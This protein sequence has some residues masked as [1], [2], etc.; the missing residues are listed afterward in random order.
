MTHEL[1]ILF[2]EDLSTD[3]ELA[4]RQLR[5]N[6]LNYE[7]LRVDTRDDF[8]NALVTFQPDLIISDYSMPGFDGMQALQMAKELYPELPFV[9]LTGSMNEDTA[10]ECMKA[11]A[12][13]YVIKEHIN[14]LPFAVRE[15]L[16][17]AQDQK[18]K[19]FTEKQLKQSEAKFRGIFE[20]A[21]VGKA[22][23]TTTETISVND[24]F[25]DLLGY[26][27]EEIVNT[28]WDQITH[29][30]DIEMTRKIDNKLYSGETDAVRYEKRYIHKNGSIIW[31]DL[32]VQVHRDLSGKPEY[33]ISTIIDISD[34]KKAGE[35]LQASEKKFRSLFQ[36]NHA[37]MLLI[38]PVTGDI[39][40]VNPA[41]IKYYGFS[42]QEL[43]GKKISEINTLSP[44]EIQEEMQ[45]ALTEERNYFNF[46]HRLAN[47]DIRDVEVYSGP[48]QHLGR[49][50]LYS[51][52]HDVTDR[53]QAEI[54]LRKSEEKFKSF[55]QNNLSV[56]LLI[57]PDTGIITDANN[58]ACHFYGCDQ[59]TLLETNICQINTLP[60]DEVFAAITRAI[61]V[62]NNSFQ[63]KHRLANGDIRDVEVN[64][65]PIEHQNKKILYSIVHDVTEK[66]QAEQQ[67]RLQATA[68]NAAANAI[69]I[70]DREGNIQWVN[71]AYTQLTGYS[72]EEVIGQN[73]RILKSG[74]QD[75]AYY[76]RLWD[77]ILSGK[78]WD[79]E[80]INKRK[81]GSLYTEDETITPMFD[82]QGNIS[83]FIEI[84]EDITQ[85]K[86]AELALREGEQRYRRLFEDSPVSIWEENFSRVKQRLDQLKA[87]GVEDFYEY[88]ATNRT[89]LLEI[90][91]LIE[92]ID[93]N[94]ETI[95][96]FGARNKEELRDN[97]TNIYT[98]QSLNQLIEEL[99]N[100]A[101]GIMNFDIDF[102][103]KTLDGRVLEFTAKWAAQPGYENTLSKVLIS[104][105]DITDRKKAEDALRENEQRYRS[106]FDDSPVTIF[107]ED[108]SAVKTFIDELKQ[109]GVKDF[110]EFLNTNPDELKRIIRSIKITD[111][112][113]EAEKLYG[114]KTKQEFYGNFEL[115]TDP[116]NLH[117]MVDELVNIAEEKTKFQT[118]VYKHDSKGVLSYL[119]VNW[120][121]VPG[122][123]DDLSKVIVTVVDI[124]E[125]KELEKRQQQRLAEMEA[126]DKITSALRQATTR[127][128]ALPI[129]LQETLAMMQVNI[130]FILLH[131]STDDT[132]QVTHVNGLA[133]EMIGAKIKPRDGI[134]GAVFQNGESR[135]ISDFKQEFSV[136]EVF[137]GHNNVDV[138]A[139]CVPIQSQE[140]ILGVVLIV[141]PKEREL[142]PDEIKLLE[143]FSRIA[144]ITLQRMTLYEDTLSHL[145]Q[146]QV[147]RTIDQT[148]A[149]IFDLNLTLEI[150]CS[151]ARNYLGADAIGILLF[152]P[153]EMTLNYIAANGFQTTHYKN[154]HI[155][156]G[157]GPAGNAALKR[158]VVYVADLRHSEPPI[159]TMTMVN[160]ERF[161]SYLA[162]PLIAKGEIKGVMEVFYRS[163]SVFDPETIEFIESLAFQ[164]AIAIDNLQLFENLQLSNQELV[165]AYDAT[166]EG[167]SRAM[168]L[169]DKET[170]NHTR[171]V[172]EMAVRIATIMGIKEEEILH[173]RRGAL[174]HDIGKMGV[175]DDILR[176]PGPLTPEEW[177]IMKQHPIF[178][179]KMIAPVDYLKP[180]LDIPY[181]HHEKWDG[182][183][184]PR[185]LKGE[186]IPI[187]GRIF[188]VI[189]VWDALSSDRPYREAWPK[190]KVL[191]YIKEQS[192][193]H[194]DPDIVKIFLE[195]VERKE[196][197]DE[198]W[199]SE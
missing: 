26:S 87:E 125:R 129:F 1:R 39:I 186:K 36:N 177:V 12:A 24:Y 56:M 196:W 158:E 95:K 166:I 153:N 15:A 107:E 22:I 178:A 185:G 50:L 180:A 57:D 162:V 79:G 67:I 104:M 124:T 49:E 44:D 100:I 72:F 2:V 152:Q 48:I 183:G 21:N 111:M 179:Y 139:V 192:G 181:C 42:Q 190:E 167:W 143:S 10:V 61:D 160:E 76:Q 108:F 150:I 70:T 91:E 30:D 7:S 182:S 198:Y 112:N 97:F 63:F 66:K 13:D 20:S 110:R 60:Q 122:F 155:P 29:P 45:R 106:L 14:R 35:E 127:D 25:A 118:E 68:M 53:K 85:R 138:G 171:R 103:N 40:D 170:E 114:F 109:S 175:P 128:E 19:L 23:T 89:Q 52:I 173:I 197:S 32:S 86:Q 34:K 27:K 189:D 151:Q 134:I 51:I 176:K 184:Y 55:F 135:S 141:H 99:V 92:V 121:A 96:L 73:P 137:A 145:K 84:K 130:G 172:T 81:D 77:T 115:I 123:E 47:G 18:E 62:D 41:A 75:H 5:T 9:V 144:G 156:L 4:E 154:A 90:A 159:K 78:V 80:L 83:H 88:F 195:V 117:L 142:K 174:L 133:E 119:T 126:I 188:A 105:V 101:N 199:K 132:L 131:N 147:Q 193:T 149:S 148:I 59:D 146:L 94:Q 58:A 169:R 98:E 3:Q 116:F 191:A 64:S 82:E 46:Q 194:F 33:L 28:P 31:V 113:K 187:A 54:Q 102:T 37:V 11:G 161:V 93:V 140:D 69:V 136:H 157:A 120:A 71:P 38:D 17:R 6:D 74:M 65:S 16:Q 163:E 8:L 168:D 164:T 43:T 165:Q